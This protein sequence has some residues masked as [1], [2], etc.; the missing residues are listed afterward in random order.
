MEAYS[1]RAQPCSS[2]SVN[3]RATPEPR[4]VVLK[5]V[6]VLGIAP[7]PPPLCP[8]EKGANGR[9]IDIR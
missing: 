8:V 9:S 5:E 3:T 1:G 4:L 6:A 2:T 7:P